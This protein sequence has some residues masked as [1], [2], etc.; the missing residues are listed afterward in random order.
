MSWEKLPRR[1]LEKILI[2]HL[3][4]DDIINADTVFKCL[5]GRYRIWVYGTVET[6][7]CERDEEGI[8]FK[9]KNNVQLLHEQILNSGWLYLIKKIVIGESQSYKYFSRAVILRYFDVAEY[10]LPK[11][12]KEYLHFVVAEN[13]GDRSVL[14]WFLRNKYDFEDALEFAIKTGKRRYLDFLRD[15]GVLKA[16]LNLLLLAGRT[17]FKSCSWMCAN[18]DFS[19]D[20]LDHLMIVCCINGN[21]LTLRWLVENKN[22]MPTRIHYD[23]AENQIATKIYIKRFL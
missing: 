22:L 13:I 18:F 1:L 15:I 4:I 12:H 11:I 19:P 20:D 9:I 2:E 23:C 16:N 10:L 21:V 5:R 7:I 6:I 17:S 14:E 3:K 8:D